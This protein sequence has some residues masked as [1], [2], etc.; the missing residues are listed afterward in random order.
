MTPE[1]PVLSASQIQSSVYAKYAFLKTQA[2]KIKLK[3]VYYTTNS[4]PK[5]QLVEVEYPV[6]QLEIAFTPIEAA[7]KKMLQLYDQKPAVGQV[8][9]NLWAC[10]QYGGCPFKERCM[11]AKS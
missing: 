2:E 7:A 1:I 4:K 8:E 6:A 5:S 3:W 9:P 10:S 11:R